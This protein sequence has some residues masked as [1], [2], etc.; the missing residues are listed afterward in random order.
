[1]KQ[2]TLRPLEY[3]TGQE[4]VQWIGT[5]MAVIG[6]KQFNVWSDSESLWK[7]EHEQVEWSHPSVPYLQFTDLDI[8]L[9]NG[10]AMRL[11]SQ[12]DDGTGFYG[13]Y[14]VEAER[15]SEPSVDEASSIFRAREVVE[16]PLGPA[17]LEV[18][19]QDGPTAVVEARIH[20]GGLEITLLAAEVHSRMDG[21]FDVVERDE[22]IL[23]QVG[24][25][26]PNP[27]IERTRPGKPGRASH[28]KR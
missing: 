13:L 21:T 27:S 12:L 3:L 23:V 26:R 4:V 19:R 24:G 9:S 6:G 8:Q 11:L 15:M 16:L 17:R 22:S 7:V 14:L 18:V 28:V 10:Q 2:P 1:M 5:E 20:I 25:A